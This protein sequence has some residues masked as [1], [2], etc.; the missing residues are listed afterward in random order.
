MPGKWIPIPLDSKLF[1][2]VHE[3]VLTRA[4]AAVE[5]SFVN[6]A[7]G[8]SRFPGLKDFSDLGGAAR[9]Y[10][11]EWR[12]DLIAVTN[13]GKVYRLDKAGNPTR[14]QGVPVSGGRRVV[15]AKTDDELLMAAGGPIIRYA[16]DKTELFSKDAPNST[17]VAFIDGF[18][19]ASEV[20]SGRFQ[21][22]SAGN[23]R[24]WSALDTFAASGSP[25]NI[26][27]LIVTPFRE[28]LVCGEES[29]EQFERLPS[30]DP[31]F[32]RR[33]SVGEGI[34]A[35]HTLVFADNAAWGINRKF[36]FVRFSGQVTQ[37]TSDDIGRSLEAIDDWT[38]AWA[39][40]IQVIGNKF[41]LL[42][43]PFATNVYGTKGATFLYDFR[44][45]KWGSLYGWDSVT[46]LP[47]RWPGWSYLSLWGRHFV[48]GE[49]RIYELTTDTFWH[50]GTPARM[51]GRTAHLS[52]LGEIRIDNLR[53]RL[54][55][56]AGTNTS[57][58]IFS[59][60]CRRDSKEWSNW[61]RK[62]LGRRGETDMFVEFGGMGAAHT[63]QWEWVITD[64]C[65]V[66][67]VKLDAQV[68][69]LGE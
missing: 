58:A 53:A 55:R 45:Q 10:M 37:P 4:H 7:G 38:D 24:T 34:F 68:T 23:F 52:E 22:S 32:F 35:P 57:E 11:A 9:V 54:R 67:L 3:A 1:L 2:N 41:I 59:I 8:H 28:L 64:D 20:D 12:G 18:V 39:E 50:A 61:K 6:E 44:Q 19:V 31:P 65:P 15:F 17:H 62:G 43:A 36:E 56:G 49:G 21:H 66:E 27:S 60:R 63:W 33:W 16:G 47:A 69:A 51:L 26:N 46:G 40:V 5:N 25:D 30:G 48:G 13:Q 29:I 14:V 42:Q